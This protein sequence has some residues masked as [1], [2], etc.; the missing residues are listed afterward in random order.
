MLLWGKEYTRR[1]LESL[2]GD[3]RQIADIELSNRAD[4]PEAGVRQALVRTGGGLEFP[5]ILDRGLDL[6]HAT[7]KGIPLTWYSPAGVTHPHRFELQGAG[8]LRTFP[9]G[10]LSL[11]GLTNVGPATSDRF[12]G[13]EVGLHGRASSLQA[14]QVSTESLWR[15]E[16]WTLQLKGTVQDAALF[17]HRLSLRRT[18]E[19]V[20]G[21]PGFK[22]TDRIRNFGSVPA[23][24]MLLYHCNF[25]WPFVGPQTRFVSPAADVVPRDEA[26]AP[27]L[28]RWREFSAPQPGFR[29]Q[30]FFHRLP[31]QR[32][33]TATVEN[34]E[35]RIAVDLKFDTSQ[36]DHLTQWKQSGAGDYVLGI[37][38]GNCPPVGQE[39]A[40]AQGELPLLPA[41]EERSFS[42]E[43]LCRDL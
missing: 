6:G 18:L 28:G 24:L 17:R 30:V 37:E 33:V 13:E 23:P 16:E 20:P 8:W 15:G 7:Y 3:L 4:G 43:I 32:Q 36:L 34:P 2:T 19:I 11:C 25:G 26:A 12:T 29:E 31:R 42:L 5:V 10:L 1:E 38:P 40:E 21:V 35:L 9:G 22:L 14:R 39:E 27:G 41:G